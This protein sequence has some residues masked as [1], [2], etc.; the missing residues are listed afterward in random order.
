MRHKRSLSGALF[1]HLNILFMGMIVV[2]MIFPL[3][4]VVS[5]SLSEGKEVLKG[6]IFLYPKGW[7]VSAYATVFK[8]PLLIR[9]FGNA[10]VY[11]VLHMLFTL[12]FTSLTA[13]PLSV[14]NY[15][16]KTFTTIFLV[17]TMFISGGMIP[18]YLLI[19]NLGMINTVWA[20]TLPFCVAA[21]NV[22]L[23]RTFFQGIPSELREAAMLDGASELRILFQIVLPLSKAILATIALFSIVGKWNDWFSALIYL[24]K[25]DLYPV[26]MILR[27]VLYSVSSIQNLDPETRAMFGRTEIT[28]QS[29]QMAV[30]VIVVTPILCIY[31]FL[32]KYFVKGVF[33][34]TIKG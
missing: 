33:I 1:D 14:P 30:V 3:L 16:L 10:I 9:S 4:H 32:Q 12:V 2:V 11:S 19:K 21:Y 20:M 13:Y 18:T 27:K 28:P 6:G 34:G 7:N 31:P 26:Q 5:V 23:F 29:I 8:D 15:R 25:E 17:I 24:T 22:V